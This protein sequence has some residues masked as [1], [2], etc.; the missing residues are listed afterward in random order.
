[1]NSKNVLHD[2]MSEFDN[3]NFFMSDQNILPSKYNELRNIFKYYIDSYIA[4]YWL[5]AKSEE[6]LNSIYNKIKIE[7]IDSKKYPPQRVIEDIL[8]IIPYNNR[9]TKSYLEIAKHISD[10]Y[11]VIE[12]NKVEAISN[13]LFYKEYGIKLDMAYFYIN[14]YENLDYN[15]E[16]TIRSAIMNN[17]LERF[18]AFTERDDFDKNQKLESKLYPYSKEGYSLLELCCYHGAVDCF[19]LL[20][21]KFYSEITQTCFHFS[22]LG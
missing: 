7:M 9:Y 22:F 16:D 8:G 21:T 20:R 5:K 14:I 15:S 10:D 11:H 1:M 19:K 2:S 6:E 17:D 3:F 4:L 13:Y 18:I 12:V